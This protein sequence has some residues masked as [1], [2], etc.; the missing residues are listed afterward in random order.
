DEDS[1]KTCNVCID[2]IEAGVTRRTLW[3]G[4]VF[5]NDCIRTWLLR[6]QRIRSR[7]T[8]G[9]ELQTRLYDPANMSCPTCR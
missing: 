3:C 6:P 5:H 7:F 9:A 4:H 1:T 2:S 8:D